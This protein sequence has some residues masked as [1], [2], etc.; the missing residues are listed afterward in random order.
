MSSDL[1]RYYFIPCKDE[2]QSYEDLQQHHQQQQQQPTIQLDHYNTLKNLNLNVNVNTYQSVGHYPDSSYSDGWHSPS[3]SSF[4]SSSPEYLNLTAREY[5]LHQ[6]QIIVPEIVNTTTTIIKPPKKRAYTKKSTVKKSPQNVTVAAAAIMKSEVSD[7]NFN[8]DDSLS[9]IDDDDDVDDDDM[10]SSDEFI[11]IDEFGSTS[12]MTP[13]STSEAG[14]TGT[15]KKR[16]N[17]QVPPVVKKKRRLAANARERK[18]MQNLNNAFDKLRQY[19][20]SLGND[21]QLSKHETLQMAQTYIT[22]L[23]DLLD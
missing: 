2:L 1:C 16:R 12:T 17:K 18:R 9:A 3:P 8:F 5:D 14:M 4:R 21:R 15:T 22:A 11:S 10:L 19:L 7:K 20:P 23:C 6:P 13:P